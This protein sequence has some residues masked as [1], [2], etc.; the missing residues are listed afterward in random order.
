MTE[1]EQNFRFS[2]LPRIQIVAAFMLIGFAIYMI[3]DQIYWWGAREDYGFGYLVPLFCAY[4]IYDRAP[5]IMSYLKFGHKPGEAPEVPA[6]S[7]A[8]VTSLFEWVA[9]AGFI[10]AA[11]LYGIGG[12][13][14]GVSGPQNPASLA[15]AAGFGG[16]MLCSVF[17]F[18]KETAD[19]KPM[20]LKRRLALTA[21]FLFPALIWLISAPL[22]S[23]LEKEI[24]VFLL[25]KVTIIVFFLLETLGFDIQREGNVLI[26]PQGQVGVE[27]ACSGILSLMACLFAGS[28]L[29]AVFLNRFWKKALLVFVA[30]CLAIFTNLCRSIFLTLWAYYNGSQAIDEPLVLP[31]IGGVGTVH[32]VAGYAILGFTCLGLIILLPIFNYRLKDFDEDFEDDE[33]LEQQK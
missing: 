16:I 25:T 27:E 18:T 28:F 15:I 11:G 5:V 22:V 17:I 21:L 29:A 8:G 3:W 12:L 7:E 6:A 31:L 4:V 30:M 9:F 2:D 24:K 13:L 33:E 19:G 1:P 26:L 14:R 10:G 23:V 32:D 20:P